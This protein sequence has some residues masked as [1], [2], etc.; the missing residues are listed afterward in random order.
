MG[1]E[2]GV[3]FAFYF[4]PSIL[5]LVR[6]ARDVVAIILV[7]LLLGWTVIGWIATLIWSLVGAKR[8]DPYDRYLAQPMPPVQPLPPGQQYQPYP[9]PGPYPQY[10]PYPTQYPP[11]VQGYQPTPPPQ[12]YTPT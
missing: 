4:L 10:P 1:I 3:G 11:P 7:N 6:G 8:H 5:A 9:Q 12:S 2:I